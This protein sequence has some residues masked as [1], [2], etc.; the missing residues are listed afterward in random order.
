MQQQSHAPLIPPLSDFLAKAWRA[1]SKRHH[2]ELEPPP[3]DE[4]AAL[5]VR[6]FTIDCSCLRSDRVMMLLVD[7]TMLQ[8]P[9]LE[10]VAVEWVRAFELLRLLRPS[11]EER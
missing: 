3:M 6:K 7:V 10:R 9:V 1:S 4:L 11:E 8:M 5:M 2:C